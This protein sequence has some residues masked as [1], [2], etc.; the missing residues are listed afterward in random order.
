LNSNNTGAAHLACPAT[1]GPV[2]PPTRLPV[3]AVVARGATWA[4]RG[5]SERRLVR[6]GRSGIRQP[7]HADDEDEQRLGG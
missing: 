6:R 7:L 5:S 2:S 3:R 4:T 1:I